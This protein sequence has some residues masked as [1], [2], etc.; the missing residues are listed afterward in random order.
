MT[1]RQFFL[2][3][4]QYIEAEKKMSREPSIALRNQILEL[5]GQLENE[6]ARV[7]RIMRQKEPQQK[8]LFG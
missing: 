2:I 1:P 8:N 6:I 5:R 4:E 7:N 3:T